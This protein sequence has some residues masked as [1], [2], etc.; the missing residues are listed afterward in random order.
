MKKSFHNPYFKWGLTAF[1]VIVASICFFFSI[2]K[3]QG[4]FS[5]IG[6]FIGI[7]KPFIY[8]ATVAYF[9][10][11]IY[12]A[13][14]KQL[15]PLLSHVVHSKRRAES[16]AKMLSSITSVMLLILLVAALLYMV[17]PQLATSIIGLTYSMQ[18]Y[19]AQISAW[20]EEF[21]QTSPDIKNNLMEIY[22]QFAGW[23]VKWIQDSMLPSM[24]KVMGGSLMGTVNILKNVIVGIIIAI[25][26]LNSK[27]LFSAQAKKITYSIFSTERA[28]LLIKNT[29]FVHRVFGG[30]ITGKLL[31]SLII[32]M[33]TFVFLSLFDMPYIV[34][35]SVVIGVTNFIPFFG[36][37][38]GGIPCAF[39][40]LMVSPLKCL[41]FVIFILVLQ[42]FDGNILGPKILGDSTGLS[43]FWVMFAILIAGG[44]FGFV[45]LIVGVPLF[46]VLYSLIS[47]LINRSLADKKLPVRTDEYFSMDCID[48]E[49]HRPVPFPTEK[50]S[51]ET[52]ISLK[53]MHKPHPSEPSSDHKDDK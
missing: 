47:S 34:L 52:G 40:M 23:A 2:F 38:I 16:C 50:P 4:L 42:Q 14:F 39:L 46:A 21:L 43:S 29:R 44:L 30:F 36:P 15:R 31:D 13:L 11:P 19:P 5:A 28:N 8:G 45:G 35:V 51:E 32:G 27:D 7:L 48:P 37:F 41:Y 24:V 33:I 18:H 25:Y 3:M 9:L 6:K 26:V 1:I 20:L 53:R 10:L 22:N 49:T 17:L 12:N